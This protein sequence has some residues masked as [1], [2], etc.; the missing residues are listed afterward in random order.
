MVVK[1]PQKYQSLF[2]NTGHMI[3]SDCTCLEEWINTFEAG[4]GE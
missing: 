4:R 3:G 2:R 1:K